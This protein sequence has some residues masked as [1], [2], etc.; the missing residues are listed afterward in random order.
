[1]SNTP[2]AVVL[3]LVSTLGYGVSFVLTQ[4]ALQRMPPWLGAAFSVPTATLLFW[5]A[6]PFSIDLANVDFNAAALF[7]GIGLFFPAAV[8][9]LNFESNRLMGANIG[10]AVAGLA[11]VFA[12]VL[13]LVLLGE[14]P[15]PA[16]WLAL[17]AIVAGVMLMDRRRQRNFPASSLWMLALPLAA[18]AIRGGVQP[19]IKLGLRQW[20]SPVAA[21]VIGYTISTVVLISAALIR[22]GGWPRRFDRRG[23]LWF[24]AVGICNGVSVLTTYA[25]LGYGTVA[26]VSPLVASYPLVTMLLGH[27]FLEDEP[28]NALML[29]AVAVT[30]G[31][32]IILIVS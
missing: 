12:V 19:V 28:I 8:T 16:Q 26:L 22:N 20:A 6:A 5:S 21:V 14:Q 25:A 32:V 3:A 18:A 23:A 29:T 9:L 30:V 1:M 7:A 4:I 13:A 15:R 24:A 27:V 2:I 31:G 17:A 11:P 10:G